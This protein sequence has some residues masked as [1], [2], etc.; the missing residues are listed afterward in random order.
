MNEAL[1]V[2]L[3]AI[4]KDSHKGIIKSLEFAQAKAPEIIKQI[5]LYG[6]YSNILYIL[7]FILVL[8]LNIFVI[9][10]YIKTKE[11]LFV[12][13]IFLF[14][15]ASLLCGIFSIYAVENLIKIQ[16]A[17]YLFLIDYIKN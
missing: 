3:L 2:E 13:F 17:P 10:K 5:F 15:I 16:T 14:S 6:V 12:P 11:E 1:Q 9:Y 4:L 7:I 8:L